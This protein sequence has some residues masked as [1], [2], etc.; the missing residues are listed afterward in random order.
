MEKEYALGM[1]SGGKRKEESGKA[2][3]TA[4]TKARIESPQAKTLEKM[5]SSL[6]DVKWDLYGAIELYKGNRTGGMDK[7]FIKPQV[8]KCKE[9]FGALQKEF[10]GIDERQITDPKTKKLLEEVRALVI[11]VREM[12]SEITGSFSN[13]ERVYKKVG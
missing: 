8:N 5:K 9:D 7:E 13:E 4:Q 12:L 6:E 1:E 3:T 2:K 10:N 11:E